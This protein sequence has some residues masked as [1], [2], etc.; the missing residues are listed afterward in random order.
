[1]SAPATSPLLAGQMGACCAQGFKHEGEAVGRIETIAGVKT[2]I[3]DPPAGA[4][5]PKKIILY[6]SDVFGPF[7]I[8]AQLLQDYFASQGT[9]RISSSGVSLIAHGYRRKATL[10]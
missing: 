9:W 5:G 8:N 7:Y 1:M 6:L 2:Y 10:F 4:T 3:S